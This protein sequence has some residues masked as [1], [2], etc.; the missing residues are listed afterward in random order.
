MKGNW[1]HD[2]HRLHLPGHSVVVNEALRN[3]APFPGNRFYTGSLR[4]S[5]LWIACIGYRGE[6]CTIWMREYRKAA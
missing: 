5:T 1:Q 4:C 3:L 2:C 6:V